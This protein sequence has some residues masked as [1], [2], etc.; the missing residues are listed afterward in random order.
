ME[1]TKEQKWAD[2]RENI[3]NNKHCEKRNLFL[4]GPESFQH[5][6]LLILKAKCHTHE[7]HK[8]A[9]HDPD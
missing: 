5:A 9:K 7:I 3:I 1:T 4:P 8:L 6:Q 2:K